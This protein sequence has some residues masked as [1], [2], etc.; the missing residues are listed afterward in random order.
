MKE[1]FSNIGVEF[2]KIAWP[3][4]KEMKLHSTQVFAFMV[5]LSLFFFA[6][7]GIVSAGMAAATG[8][9]TPP[10]PIVEEYDYDEDDADYD[11]D[12]DADYENG[13]EDEETA[14]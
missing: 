1:F 4:D 14:E 6:V 11:Y 10:P 7:D 8:P 5:V 2:K 3:T 9:S 13:D 12:Y